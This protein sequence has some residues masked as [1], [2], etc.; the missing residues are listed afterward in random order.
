MAKN[1]YVPPIGPKVTP[2]RTYQ[3]GWERTFGKKKRKA[4]AT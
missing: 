2:G 4:K 3:K 1:V